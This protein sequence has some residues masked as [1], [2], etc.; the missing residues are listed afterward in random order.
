LSTPWESAAAKTVDRRLLRFAVRDTCRIPYNL[1]PE[2]PR[3][4]TQLCYAKCQGD[5]ALEREAILSVPVVTSQP[6]PGDE[7]MPD[8]VRKMNWDR[9]P[10]GAMCNWPQSLRTAV[11]IC[12]KSR[13][14]M[15]VWWGPELINIYNDAY[16]PVL[17]KRHPVALGMPAREI[18]PD[19]WPVIS[20]EVDDVVQRGIA[21]VKERV[22][23][24]LERNGYPE[25]TW[26]TYSHSPILDDDGKIGG[27]F[28]LC[29]DETA[30][31]QAEKERERLADQRQL[32][33]D[34]ARMG[35][36]HYDPE[37][38]IAS[39][40]RRYC[41][42]FGVSG[43]QRANEEI[44]KRLH[45]DDLRA[46]WAKV[47]AALNPAD[48]K[49][50]SAQY[51]ILHDDGAVRWVEAHGAATF[52][53]T[54]SER[55]AV[56][57]VG[58]VAD[59]TDQK[60]AETE[61]RASEAAFR[62]L[63]DAM[64][65]IVWAAGPN[66][67]LD[68]YNRRWFEYIAIPQSQANESTVWDRYV[69]PDDLPRVG[70]TWQASLRSGEKYHTEFRVR[71]GDGEYRW[72][73]VRAEPVRDGTG[74]IVRWF[75]TCTDI[76]AMKRMT[77]ERESLLGSERAAR[78]EAERAGRMKDEFLA[79][80]SHELRTPLNAILGWA[81]ILDGGKS[82]EADLRD[83]LAAIQRNAR[84]QT[85]I[86]EDLLDMS[87]I[88]SGKVRLDV[89]QVDLSD[90]LRSSVDSVR[91]AAEAKGVR[92]RALLDPHAGPVS[93][94]PARLQQVFWNLLTN[95]VK[96]T[97]K[98]GQVQVLLERVNSHLEASVADTGEG[99]RPEFLPHVFDRFRQAD[100]STTRRH[101]GLGLGLSIV[102]QLVELHG[103]T[104]RVKSPGA[105]KGSTFTIVLPL[106]VVHPEPPSEET[107]DRRHPE[108]PSEGSADADQC[109]RLIGVRVVVVDDEPDA[110]ALIKR[111][112]EE[113]DAI[114]RTAASANEAMELIAA[115]CPDVLVSDIGMPHEDGY[116]LIRR[117]RALGTH[118]AADIPA[119]ALTAYA[120]TE[121][122]VRAI[123]AGFQ[124]H[125][126]KPVEAIELIAVVASLAVRHNGD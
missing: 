29:S 58:T 36:W 94:D 66:G 79:T 74:S 105:G 39:F 68:Y 98:G 126:V 50:Y 73:L 3:H 15:F 57:F 8:R 119:V 12:L 9:T 55:K 125:V 6:T 115:E 76:D 56:R 89:Q 30:H 28:Q 86:I 13:F 53:G 111:L 1:F 43:H 104:V 95:A 123:R 25:E 71:G 31:V 84:A 32:A 100:A 78:A 122:R 91:P 24:V 110:R 67:V 23:L 117:V 69:H 38:K 63:A 101:G 77:Q 62:Q 51:R 46:V 103:G 60:K 42:I 10:L 35:W 99:I 97:L 116:A 34:A 61:T 54:G 70:E 80:L 114:V 112:L 18:W 41:E 109:L 87:R 72:F 5:L 88:V 102:K 48:P 21:V 49:P 82:N 124:A 17:G 33:L 44:L 65:Q 59:I 113:C 37:T 90:V 120:R 96:F 121:D 106:T 22:R 75:G 64:P 52:E 47:E 107:L 2:P 83:G 108:A 14:P 4:A 20:K 7:P 45:P 11:D 19:I 85:Q 118:Q 26:F 92:I 27:L 16:A 93:G 81:T 40:D